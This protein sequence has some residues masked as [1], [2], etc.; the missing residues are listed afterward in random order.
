MT[1]LRLLAR[2]L[3]V[4][5]LSWLAPAASAFALDGLV[6]DE[7]SG[8]PIPN[9][10]VAILGRP[11]AVYTDAEGR[12]TWRPTPALP[13]EVLVILPGERYTKPVLVE[14]LPASGVLEVRVSMLV[15]E[16]VTVTAGAAPDIEATPGAA[17]A[18]LSGREVQTRMPANLAQVLEN[19]AGVSQVSEGQAAVPAIRGLARG[20]TVILIDGARVSA[21]RRVGPSATFLDPFILD[22]VEVAR[23][24][25]SVAYGS[26]AFGGVILARTRRVEPGA[27]LE[28]RSTATLGA[29][30]PE[31]RV[32]V[33]LASGLGQT[34]S[35][36]AE[37]HF[38]SFG[39]YDSPRGE[40]FNSGALDKGFL[41]RAARRL[42]AGEV[43]VSWQSDFGGDIDRPRNNSR[44]VR[45][46]YPTED[47]HRLTANY[48]LTNTAGFSRID[49]TGFLGSYRVVTDQDRY[50]TA[51]RGRSLE[52]GDVDANDFQVRA[53]AER[54]FGQ[55]R[56]EVGTDVHGRFDLHALDI[57]EQ[58]DT[59]GARASRVENVSID[60]ARRTDTGVFAMFEV[61]P[62]NTLL[63]AGGARADHVATRNR[64]GYF[65]DA[66]TSNG[67]ASGFASATVG[68][69]GGVSLTG[70]VARGFRDPTLSDRYYRGPTGRGFITGNPDLDPETSLQ[71]DG[72]VRYTA[73]KLR[74]A[75]YVFHYR[76]DDLIERYE[77]TT[78]FFF[79]RNRGRARIR[80]VEI[81]AMATLTPA[82]TLEI[83]GHVQRGTALDDEADL[84]DIAP[85]TLTLQVRHQFSSRVSAQVRGAFFAADDRPGPT[86][87]ARSSY[88]VA[89]AVVG[90]RLSD[91]V[92]LRGSVRNLFDAA[93][94]VSPDARAVYAP[95]RSASV[96]VSARF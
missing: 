82:T 83:S 64:A 41:L 12:F 52:R 72:G 31:G 91:R 93:Y 29:G 53:S 56:L 75:A 9:A 69:F 62:R 44:T 73:A 47:S 22:G 23:G 81:E 7:R 60:S 14:Q 46:F 70:Q 51:T 24:P 6:I 33:A 50:A 40:V 80:G 58:Y 32:A 49:V 88:A 84:D 90:V 54:L 13:F 26:D 36:L 95:G 71:W 11:G 15:E 68:P 66:S 1:R 85:D 10:E 86:E 30:V 3:C 94:L 37:A 18:L 65:G 27:P 16:T 57:V 5:V 48:S 77:T 79:F 76:I 89:D 63:L 87:Q 8:K 45:F 74:L 42:G 21:E 28:V 61:A 34:G 92:E 19:V 55:A 25:G 39:D 35:M 4:L 67:S 96:T 38:R 43:T 20:R 59:T 17:T 2:A 78:D